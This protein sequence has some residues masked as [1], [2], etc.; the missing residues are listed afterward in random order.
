MANSRHN[1]YVSVTDWFAKQSDNTDSQTNV[2]SSGN[3][4]VGGFGGT[5][6]GSGP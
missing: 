5:S 1:K 6:T 4:Y 2:P 3:S